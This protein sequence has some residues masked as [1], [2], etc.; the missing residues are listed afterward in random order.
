MCGIA[1][2]VSRNEHREMAAA[3]AVLDRMCRVIAHRGPDDQGML[4]DERVALGMRR[5]S[6]IDL[7]GGHQPMSG[8]GGAVTIVF[9]GEIY[10]Y[11]ELQRE[12][13]SRG[14]QFKTHSD[15][16]T[17]VHT[18]EEYGAS[19][20]EH[21]RG[22]FAFAIWDSRSRELFIARDRVGKKPLYYTITP[23]GTLMFGSELKSLREHPEFRAEINLEA[24]DAYLTFGYVPDPLTI[25]RDVHKL[26]PGHYLMFKDDRVR[27]E[28]YWDFPYEHPQQ[29][30]ARSEDECLE[31]LRELLDEAVRLRMEAD[32]PLGAFLSGGVD[33][34]TVV[35]LMS[36][37]ASQ[38]VKTF[39]IGFHED[40]YNELK[41]ARIAAERFGTDHH[42]FV[43]TPDICEIVDDLVWHFDEP[44]ADSSAIPTYMVSKLA[45]EHVTVALSG[46]GGDELFA[47][48]TRYALDRKRSGFA[49]LPRVVRQG[50]MQP[51]GRNLPHGAWGRNYLHNVALDPLDRYIE[52]V[53]VFTRLNRPSLYTKSFQQQLGTSEAAQRFRELAARSRA[54]ASLDP[55]LYLDSKTYLPGDILTKVDRMSMAV[56]LE[57]RVPLLDHKLIEFVC[58]RIP[59][60]MKMKGLETKHIF[61]RAVRD[62]VP[63]EILDR[64]KQG[65]G[66]PI[67]QWINQ[68]LR[69]RVRGTLTEPRT[70]QRGYVEPRYVQLLLDEHERGRRD[71]A[72]E[73]WTL[74]MLELWQRKFVDGSRDNGISGE[75]NQTLAPMVA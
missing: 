41:Y 64:P 59:A 14:H 33:S 2:F 21:L 7:P 63:T 16:E 72:T 15:T 49:N 4:V 1:G 51:L 47:G 26:P 60:S 42:E 36:R 11:R 29:N 38:P 67:D 32:V 31:E 58:T 70:M 74:F 12:L 23:G 73:L 75:L 34:S 50:V 17:I 54:D 68:Q 22:M 9:N 46:D 43:V 18:Y 19:C 24:L 13:E 6:I 65:F 5:L 20:V 45:R 71:H 35:G 39:S 27:V 40:S 28:Q 10:N 52:D 48:Y 8:C 69:E 53:S 30:P 61:K 56:S 25:F 55:L 62:L 3:R 37:H 44:F 57:A 66:I